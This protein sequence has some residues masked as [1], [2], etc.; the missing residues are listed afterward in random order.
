MSISQIYEATKQSLL[1]QQSAINTTAKNIA[2]ANTEGYTRRRINLSKLSLGFS[3]MN[4]ESVTRVKNQFVDSQL[5]YEKQELGKQSMNEMLLK[6]VEGIYGEP[7][8]SGLN[9]IMNEFWNSWSNLANNPESESARAIVKDKGVMLAHTFNRLDKNIKNVQLQVGGEIEQK[10]SEINGI[11]KQIKLLNTQ[12]GDG[13][14]IDLLDQ[15]DMLI[16]NLSSKIDI[17]VNNPEKG[18]LTIISGGNILVSGG[19]YNELSVK[20][21]QTSDGVFN[22]EINKINGNKNINIS[23][24][25]LGGLIDFHNN[26][27]AKNIQKLNTIANHFKSAINDIHKTGYNL[28]SVTGMAFFSENTSGAGDFSVADEIISDPSLI[29]SSASIDTPGD[30]SIAQLMADLKYGDVIKGETIEDFYTG[31]VTELGN[32]VQQAKF[33]KDNQARVI[34]RLNNQ[35]A[36]VS[37]VSLDEEMTNLIKFEQA[38]Q[39]AA[40]MVGT[41]DELMDTVLR[42]V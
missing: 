25:E 10:V 26:Y 21:S 41:V 29:A 8:D 34:E 40:R 28:N 2:N 39:A 35:K 13:G 16:D 14:S 9:N 17:Q 20:T 4:G 3:E 11:V 31:V 7:S 1:T 27:V 32:Q 30:G 33:I 38:Y 6:Q 42:M 18:S 22:I 23:S 15:R 24:G 36:T 37:G 19:H 12:I 5:W